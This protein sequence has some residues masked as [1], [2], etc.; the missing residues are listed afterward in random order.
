MQHESFFPGFAK[1]LGKE[2][3]FHGARSS[4]LTYPEEPSLKVEEDEESGRP[5]AGG[6]WLTDVH[7]NRCAGRLK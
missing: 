3:R 5:R 6:D 4:V 7:W 1:K 2:R